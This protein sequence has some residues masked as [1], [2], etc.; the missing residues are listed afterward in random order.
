MILYPLIFILSFLL[1]LYL[2]PIMRQAAL[3]FGIVDHPDGQLKTQSEPVAYLGGLALYLSFLVALALVYEFDRQVL[4]LL[5]GGTIVV[6]LGLI[7]DFGFLSPKVKLAGQLVAVGVLLKSGIYVQ[8]EFLPEIRGIPIVAYLIS[9]LWLVGLSNA[10]NIIDVM[11]G[12]ASI[13]AGIAAFMLFGVAMWNDRPTIA[14]LT[15]AL[16]GG[17]IGFLWYNK[18]PAKIYLGDTG[19]LFIGMML[20]SLAMIGSYTRN[21]D[22]AYLAP[23]LILGI[24]IFDT[25]LVMFIRWLKKRPVMFGSPDHYALRLRKMGLSVRGVLIMS[26]VAGILLGGAAFWLMIMRSEIHAFI[27]CSVMAVVGIGVAVW[28]GRVPMPQPEDERQDKEG[29]TGD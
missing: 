16:A 25:F 21:N 27:L 12:L 22:M 8:L 7:D 28:I 2:T 5:L 4:G 19:S 9:V 6:I 24:P 23:V 10:F 20:G 26:A 1:A 15:L 18:P 14:V 13:T 29:V 3:R 17:L 11:D